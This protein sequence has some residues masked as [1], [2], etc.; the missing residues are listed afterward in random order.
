MTAVFELKGASA[1]IAGRLAL[2]AVTLSAK[3]GEVVGVVGPN[4]AGKTTLLRAILGLQK[5]TGGSAELAG[6]PVTKLSDAARA[7]LVAYLPQ[8]RA[9]GWN[10]PAWRLASLGS[11]DLAPRQAEIRA[12]AAL[13][14]VGLADLAERGVLDMSGGERARVLLARLLTAQAPLLL[15]DEPVASL[16][17]A[18]QLLVL[19]ILREEAARGAAVVVSLHDLTLATRYCD[20][21][22][23]LS[24]G[25]IVVDDA[26]HVALAPDVLL[27]TFDLYGIIISTDG[28]DV[29]AT[30]RS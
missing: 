12:R 2:D 18:A 14:R 30:W 5:L 21:L 23:V 1:V 24:H 15:A 6:R 13:E 9:V 20:R 7:G 28:G 4:G 10:L 26:P 8:D 27:S 11:P 3:P 19:D 22:V 17:P 29:L 25:H 16:D